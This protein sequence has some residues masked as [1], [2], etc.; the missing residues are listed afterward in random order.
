[1]GGLWLYPLV[2]AVYIPCVW[3][4][5]EK[6]ILC[7]QIY[8]SVYKTYWPCPQCGVYADWI[9]ERQSVRITDFIMWFIVFT[10]YM[11]GYTSM[12]YS[13]IIEEHSDYEVQYIIDCL[14]NT[15]VEYIQFSLHHM[16]FH[17]ITWS[18]IASH[19]L[20]FYRTLVIWT[21]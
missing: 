15:Q 20:S 2:V 8:P 21:I 13:V 6:W 5:Q 19:D 14:H 7:G 3:L 4:L 12:F 9:I 11:S 18:F 17:C 10:W 16:I 1:M